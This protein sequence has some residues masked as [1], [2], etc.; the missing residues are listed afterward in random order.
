MY[1]VITAFL[2]SVHCLAIF[3]YTLV[4]LNAVCDTMCDLFALLLTALNKKCKYS[5]LEFDNF[6]NFL[7]GYS[8]KPK[9]RRPKWHI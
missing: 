1:V 3:N 9:C 2:K 8:F 7:K 4:F 5:Y 6:G